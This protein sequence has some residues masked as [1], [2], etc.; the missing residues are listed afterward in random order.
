MSFYVRGQIFYDLG[1]DFYVIFGYVLTDFKKE[2][3][4]QFE[5]R[6]LCFFIEAPSFYKIIDS[7]STIFYHFYKDAF[8]KVLRNKGSN[9]EPTLYAATSSNTKRYTFVIPAL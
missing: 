9:K 1:V 7:F 2:E 8:T 3:V 5:H 6:Y 4:S